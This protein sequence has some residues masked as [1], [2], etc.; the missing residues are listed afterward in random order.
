MLQ[1][2]Q[3]VTEQLRDTQLTIDRAQ[4][5]AQGG[6]TLKS[7]L[8][9]A[10]CYTLTFLEIMSLSVTLSH[11]VFSD[12]QGV[13]PRG[14]QNSPQTPNHNPGKNQLMLRLSRG[15]NLLRDGRRRWRTTGELQ[16]SLQAG[17][18]E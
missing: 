18:T 6:L 8:S 17:A 12:M 13:L 11:I 4:I 10:N 3:E 2:I 5:G 16:V 9:T 14:A 15:N 7:G 1:N